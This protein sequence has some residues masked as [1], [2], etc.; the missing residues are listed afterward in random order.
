MPSRQECVYSASL[1]LIKMPKMLEIFM[2]CTEM[3]LLL[4]EWHRNG[5]P[6][7]RRR[8]FELT[9]SPHSGQPVKFDENQLQVLIKELYQTPNGIGSEDGKPSCYCHLSSSLTG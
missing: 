2:L 6:V 5:F 7:P 8:Q 4:I 1:L 9:D 3:T